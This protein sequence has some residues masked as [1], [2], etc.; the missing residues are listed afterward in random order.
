LITSEISGEDELELVSWMDAGGR[1]AKGRGGYTGRRR[2]A[3]R[4]RPE[5]E[6]AAAGHGPAEAWSA[7]AATPRDGWDR[8]AERG[9]RDDDAVV[10][11]L[12]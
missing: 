2:R 12:P 4:P 6:R 8:G 7:G 1:R 10:S 11:W 9:R 3:R 5:A